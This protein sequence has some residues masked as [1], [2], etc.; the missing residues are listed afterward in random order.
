[1]KV[2]LERV[3]EGLSRVSRRV[4]EGF[5]KRL[6]RQCNIHDTAMYGVLV[7]RLGVY[8]LTQYRVCVASRCREKG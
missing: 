3:T 4:V 1:M 6:T 8:G 5:W 7:T 2:A